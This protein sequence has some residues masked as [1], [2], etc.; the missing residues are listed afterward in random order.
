[1]HISSRLGIQNNPIE[2]PDIRKQ[3]YPCQNITYFLAEAEETIYY[4]A[5]L[6]IVQ[7]EG[8]P[9]RQMTKLF[10]YRSLDW[11]GILK[12]GGINKL[13]WRETISGPFS[14]EA[15]HL[16]PPNHDRHFLSPL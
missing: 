9:L 13:G 6:E 8:K 7:P 3:I 5:P 16:P 11:E 12:C 2:K 15:I 1:V 4:Y 10:I 14:L